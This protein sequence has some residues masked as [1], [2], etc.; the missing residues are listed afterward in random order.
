MKVII[1]SNT[2]IPDKYRLDSSAFQVFL[3]EL[4]RT[5]HSLCVPKL[6][7]DEIEN[8]Y[9][10][11]LRSLQKKIEGNVANVTRMTG[12]KIELSI[13][14]SF[15]QAAIQRYDEELRKKLASSNATILDYPDISHEFLVERALLRKRPFKG[16]DRDYR[17]ALIWYS[18]VNIMDQNDESLA[19]ITND[20]GFYEEEILHPDLIEDI[21]KRGLHS[22]Q[23]H[24]FKKLEEFNEKH[25]TPQLEVLTD[26]CMQLL[27]GTYPQM[28]VSQLIAERLPG[29]LMGVIG[30]DSS[31][32]FLFGLP[33]NATDVS[34][35]V[36]ADPQVKE[37]DV[38]KLS[39][40]ALLVQVSAAVECRFNY[41]LLSR[42]YATPS[43]I[44][45]PP[46]GP[47]IFPSGSAMPPD[48]G[49]YVYP[50]GTLASGIMGQEWET[51]STVFTHTRSINIVLN[52]TFDVK[53][54]T[55][56]SMG[57]KSISSEFP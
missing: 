34:V 15:I 53:S 56:I 24:M 41:S 55:V 8:K 49:S 2:V 38:R 54:E 45:A 25:I 13:N 16:A 46:M 30:S 51:H 31:D 48:I 40:E 4:D 43:G 33:F 32:R 11:R 12:E 19:F 10:E 57:I 20:S 21:E 18:I 14:E 23:V 36:I 28:N 29:L 44:I 9:A 26:V 47:Y 17:D 6:V 5:G 22:K 1:D 27:Q 42:E 7:I 37:V 50:I 3:G 35:S 39:S 52:I